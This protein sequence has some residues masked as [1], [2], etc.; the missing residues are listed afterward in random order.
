MSGVG[1]S[2]GRCVCVVG[3][4][5]SE[6]RC[7]C[8]LWVWMSLRGVCVRGHSLDVKGVAVLCITPIVPHTYCLYSHKMC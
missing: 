3:V 2:E 7:V 1:D 6:G 8:V 5:V 4:G